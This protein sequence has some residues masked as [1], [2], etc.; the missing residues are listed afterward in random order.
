[1]RSIAARH[2]D[3]ERSAQ[4]SKQADR[5]NDP[6]LGKEPDFS[7]L[8]KPLTTQCRSLIEGYHALH[9]H[10]C[11]PDMLWKSGLKEFIEAHHE[12]RQLLRTAST[13]RSAKKSNESFMA[14]AKIILSLEILASN[15]S[16]WSTIYPDAGLKAHALLLANQQSGQMPLM[17]FYLYQSKYVTTAARGP[18][19]PS[20]R[21]QFGDADMDMETAFGATQSD[22]P[23]SGC[24]A[25]DQ[26]AP[27]GQSPGGTAALPT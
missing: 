14:I 21:R 20:P 24:A 19:L 6:D 22:E 5:G 26:P 23:R 13:T 25:T 27:A 17:D 15:F 1:M 18:L 8:P 7:F 11:L 3:L 10:S 9:G 16:G 12:C 2:S 4:T